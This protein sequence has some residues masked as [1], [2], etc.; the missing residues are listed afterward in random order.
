MQNAPEPLTLETFRAAPRPHSRDVLALAAVVAVLGLTAVLYA[1]AWQNPLSAS[2]MPG[3]TAGLIAAALVL[4]RQGRK[5]WLRGQATASRLAHLLHHDPGTQLLNLSG[6]SARLAM[7]REAGLR[8]GAWQGFGGLLTICLTRLTVIRDEVGEEHSDAAFNQ[9]VE[10]LRGAFG[11]GCEIALQ[12]EDTLVVW[13]RS[14]S[15]QQFILMSDSLRRLL[16]HPL[17]T[18]AGPIS[19]QPAIG[20]FIA[21]VDL[22]DPREAVRRARLALS[23][24]KLNASQVAFYEPSLDHSGRLRMELEADLRRALAERQVRMVYQPQIN[25]RGQLVGV[26]ALIRWRHPTRGDIPPSLFVPMAESSGLGET[27]GEFALD[28][29]MKDAKRWTDITV[30]VNVSP[31]QLRSDTFLSVVDRLLKTHSVPASRFELE[32]TEG[33]LLERHPTVLANLEGLR[34]RGFLIALDDFG[35]GYSGLSYLN[36]FEV[37]KI[38]VDQS[39]VRNLGERDEASAIIRAIVGLSDALGMH[40]LAEGVE[41]GRQLTMLRNEGCKLAQGYYVGKPA[42]AATIDSLASGDFRNAA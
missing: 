4:A 29:A 37:D 39:F 11:A 12:N 24:A 17:E 38:K 16:E 1:F 2:A 10:R 14:L 34:R 18:A 36:H 41:S 22:H 25:E 15:L 23:A 6:L 32:I 5:A 8:D 26:E 13:A 7:H 28:T 31:V 21:D 30:A 42:P 33:I 20:T 27:L 19:L 35:T 3:V 40:V 9:A